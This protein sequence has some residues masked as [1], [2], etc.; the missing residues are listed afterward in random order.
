MLRL[1]MVLAVPGLWMMPETVLAEEEGWFGLDVRVEG[2]GRFWNPVVSAII[3]NSIDKGSPA[4]N[5][6]IAVGDRII[7]VDG[8]KVAGKR[9]RSLVPHFEKGVGESL[10]LELV[11]DNQQPHRVTLV[12]GRRLAP[13][14]D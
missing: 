13:S 12:G 6:G 7:A 3:V 2:E 14:L 5:A 1:M 10:A 8:V 4:E 11:G 9:M